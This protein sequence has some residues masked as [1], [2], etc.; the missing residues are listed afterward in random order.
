MRKSR[1]VIL[2]CDLN[3]PKIDHYDLN[4]VE[5]FDQRGDGGK[6]ASLILRP[7]GV[8][9]LEDSYRL[10]L[11]ENNEEYSKTKEEQIESGNLDSTPLAVSH[12]INGRLKKRYDYIMI[13]PHWIVKKVEYRYQEAIDNGGDHAV[14][15]AYLEW[16]GAKKRTSM[17]LENVVL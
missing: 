7:N 2:C 16:T 12:V 8:H 5:F 15:V 1:P 3:E 14:V 9:D 4:K 11:T 13:S 17:M 10:W 6:K